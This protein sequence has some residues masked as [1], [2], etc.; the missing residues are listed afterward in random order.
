[1]RSA[2]CFTLIGWL[3]FFGNNPV[4]AAQA[5]N[6]VSRKVEVDTLQL[7]EPDSLRLAVWN[8]EIEPGTKDVK[9]KNFDLVVRAYRLPDTAPLTKD[10]KNL[11]APTTVPWFRV[12]NNVARYYNWNEAQK[13]HEENPNYMRENLQKLTCHGIITSSL[14]PSDALASLDIR[15]QITMAKNDL[16]FIGD[17]HFKPDQPGLYRLLWQVTRNHDVTDTLNQFVY[18]K[19]PDYRLKLRVQNDKLLHHVSYESFD[20]PLVT[21]VFFEKNSDSLNRNATDKTFRETF[22]AIA[23]K[24]MAEKKYAAN[25]LGLYDPATDKGAK[26]ELA[27]ARAKIFQTLLQNKMKAMS[28]GWAGETQLLA[29]HATKEEWKNFYKFRP[30]FSPEQFSQENRAA[31]LQPQPAAAER[32]ILAPWEVLSNETSDEV[33]LYVEAINPSDFLEK[34]LQRGEIVVT[35]NSGQSLTEAILPGELLPILRGQKQIQL[36][37]AP[38]R[39]FLHHGRY[40]ARLHLEVS[41]P[42]G[43]VWSEPDTFLIERRLNVTHDVIFALNRYDTTEFANKFD[44]ERV[45]RLARELLQTAKD[46]LLHS[47]SPQPPDALVLISGHSCILGNL[48]SP[49]YNLGLSFGRAVTLRKLLLDSIRTQSQNFGITAQDGVELCTAKSLISQY[50]DKPDIKKIID[51]ALRGAQASDGK[52]LEASYENYLQRIINEKVRHF[53]VL[54]GDSKTRPPGIPDSAQIVQRIEE[55]KH[56]LPGSVQT[57]ELTDGRKNIKV[58]FVAVGFG[59]AVPFYRRFKITEETR[60]AFGRMGFNATDIPSSFY[61]DDRYPAGRLMNRRIEVNLIW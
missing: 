14:A 55:L 56:V 27:S 61:G 9:L 17:F 2:L 30:D 12:Y 24:R 11:P 3:S 28:N 5:G 8:K 47:P 36:T 15:S 21:S 22:I 31:I 35:D 37:S 4:E 59:S 45:G 33:A 53:R 38:M 39:Q 1:M 18:F 23:A 46:T 60:E 58:H 57:L 41:C 32:E 10:M 54:A 44:Y 50:I 25:L 51:P 20:V 34:C 29:R 48:P 16:V 7:G 42:D 13:K 6:A 40:V 49:L 52:V 26:D 43:E 19:C